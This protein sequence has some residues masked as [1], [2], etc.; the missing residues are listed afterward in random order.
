MNYK[1]LCEIYKDLE[2]NPSRL[3]KT[4]ILSDFLKKIKNSKDKQVIYLLQGKVYPDYS[5]KEFGISEQLVIKTL[6]KAS[7]E[8][9]KKIVEK[10]KKLGDLGLV[11]EQIINKKKQNTLFSHKLTTEK[12]LLNLQKLPELE[13]K[14]SIDKKMSLI[15]EL[16]TSAKGIEAKYIVRTLIGQLRIGVASGTIRDAIVWAC[17]G[18]PNEDESNK[19]RLKQA[20]KAVQQSYDKANDFSLVLDKAYKGI[21][22]LNLTKLIPG[23]PIKVMLAL[24]TESI[25]DGFKRVGKPA[26]FEYKYDGFRMIINKTE[27]GEIKIFTRRLDDVTNQFPDVVSYIKEH[28][29]SKSFVIDS[30]AIGYDSKTK[31]YKPFEAISQRIKRKYHIEKLI[32]ELPI[33][34][35][36]F[37]ILYHNGKSLIDEPFKKRTEILRKIIKPHKYKIRAAH[38]LIT[39]NEKKAEEFYKK[40]LK[41]DQEG[42]MIKNLNSPYK[43]G[44]RVGHMLKLKPSENE[45]DLVITSAE[46]GKGKRAGAFASFTLSCFDEKNNKFLEIGKSSGLKEKSEL[47][48][49]FKEITN[50]INPLIISESGREVNI[51]PQIVVTILYQNIQRSPTYSSGFALRFPRIINLRPDRS[52]KDIATLKEI[53]KDYKRH[54]LKIHF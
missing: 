2:K 53:S 17:F 3:K 29:K 26:V 14:G 47:G 12:V 27:K 1:E 15:S 45:L 21:K 51:K 39:D 6:S 28:I 33:E 50:L 7:G 35:N 22:E 34:V 54:E 43:P 10:W 49:S 24:K 41:D 32:K 13:G 18:K 37:D 19:E 36:V 25:E 23:K 31:K 44:A 30:E 38:Q 5:E 52:P 46:Y 20:T 11:A 16:L 42:V 9:T 8:N 48:L 40:S 4:E